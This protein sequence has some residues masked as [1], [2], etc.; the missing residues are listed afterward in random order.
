MVGQDWFRH[1]ERVENRD[2][3]QMFFAETMYVIMKQ[4]CL[5]SILRNCL[6]RLKIA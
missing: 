4:V 1:N 3:W 5:I 2:H 6:I